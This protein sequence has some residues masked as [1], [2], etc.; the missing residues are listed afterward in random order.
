MTMRA[1][2]G[3]GGKTYGRN[4]AIQPPMRLVACVIL[5][6]AFSH[7]PLTLSRTVNNDPSD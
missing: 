3:N 4:T 7:S 1:G 2:K 6:I 5:R